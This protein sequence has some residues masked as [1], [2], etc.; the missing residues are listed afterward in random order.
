MLKIIITKG[1]PGSGKTTWARKWVEES[2]KDRVRV[3]RDDIRNLL[4]PYWIPTRE[5]LVTQ[6]E[7]AIIISSSFN[8]YSVVIDAT[9]FKGLDRFKKLL[10]NS[11]IIT[12]ECF[13][14][15]DFEIKDFTDVPLE[16]CISRDKLRDKPVG[17]KVIRDFH[18]KYI[19][20]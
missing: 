12:P 5:D 2:P 10:I 17:E 3:N 16:D 14:D 11:P 9:N 13:N 8:G 15:I 6:I 1:L 18:N 20:K 4:G 19:K 7:D